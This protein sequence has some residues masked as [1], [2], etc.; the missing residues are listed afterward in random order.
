M[1]ISELIFQL[2]G[3]KD[4]VGDVELRAHDHCRKC[5]PENVTIVVTPTWDES[6]RWVC[7]ELEFGEDA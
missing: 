3:L 5:D 4:S 7:V 6:G 1:R 2:D